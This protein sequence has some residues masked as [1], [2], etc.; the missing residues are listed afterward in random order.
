MAVSHRR[1]APH[2]YD[3]LAAASMVGESCLTGGRTDPYT[4][5]PGGNVV[6]G[7]RSRSWLGSTSRR[8]CIG[9]C[10]IGLVITL[11]SVL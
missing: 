4:T 11:P 5:S 9:G 6:R 8:S 10:W 1:T 7:G 2:C 3:G